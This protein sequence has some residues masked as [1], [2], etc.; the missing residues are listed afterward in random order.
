MRLFKIRYLLGLLLIM[1]STLT[2]TA[3][4][5]PADPVEP[6][7]V[8]DML[9]Y[10]VSVAASDADAATVSGSGKYKKGASV[11]VKATAKTGYKF[12]YW[13]K[14]GGTE[15]YNTASSFTYTMTA[16][17]V[18]FLA[19]FEKA[20]SVTVKI[21]DSNAGTVSGSTSSIYK[22]G[23]TTISTTAKTNYVFKYWLKDDETEPYSTDKSFKYTMQ[24]E[25]VTFT[26]VYEYVKPEY[27]PTDPA[28]PGEYLSKL[29]YR[30]NVGISDAEA[31]V[32]SGA[33][34][35]KYGT[36]V[37]VATS[38]NAGYE[39]R[40]WM[41]GEEEYSTA[42]SFNYTVS[43]EDVVFTAEYEYV[44][45]P[46]PV[47]TEHNVYLTASSTGCC[48]FN[49]VNGASVTIG[50]DFSVK[51]TPGTEFRF[52]GWYIGDE[53][54]CTNATYEGTMG[55]EDITLKAVC[56]YDPGYPVEPNSLMILDLSCATMTLRGRTLTLHAI[57]TSSAAM[58][59][60]S[61]SSS[62]TNVVT[63]AD[64]VVTAVDEGRATITAV[65]A[66]GKMTATCDITVM[67][68]GKG[69]VT[70]DGKITIADVSGAVLFAMGESALST[71]DLYEDAADYNNNG[72]VTVTDAISILRIVL[73]EEDESSGD[74]QEQASAPMRVQRK[75]SAATAVLSVDGA[76][77]N[78]GEEVS[79]PVNFTLKED[80][81]ISFQFD[82]VLPEGIKLQ[83]VNAGGNA[84]K[85]TITASRKKN[86]I[87]V[88]GYSLSNTPFATKVGEDILYLNLTADE[89]LA[90][91][92]YSITMN[93]I[94]LVR[95]NIST[96]TAA[97]QVM[98][99]KVNNDATAIDQ[100]TAPTLSPKSNIIYDM[101][102]RRVTNPTKGIY[103]VNGKKQR[104]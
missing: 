21:S 62:N 47:P 68:V 77:M 3:Q 97:K 1:G 19:V 36:S 10:K 75:A 81:F 39:F 84:S 38:A 18:S 5:N 63:V 89:S 50:D 64:G 16:E 27:K 13:T 60:S 66:D 2:A 30:V 17:D 29:S 33:G 48:T 28:E 4:Y 8:E 80:D 100:L 70:G 99:V 90:S 26:A 42:Q 40:R 94:E 35:Y 54:V 45:I 32:V 34:K 46:E 96:E 104:F 72:I 55:E 44:G 56:E 15:S 37:A 93:N 67:N 95:K 83:S 22:G 73:N 71:R 86:Y 92:E 51:A 58:E 61:W 87:R 98:T 23:S 20:K 85:Q 88:V 69:D 7:S 74:S 82:L 102:G 101:T 49:M 91:G 25:N 41:K 53:L 52:V 43:D 14:D 79:V 24:D 57:D 65:S 78:A 31:G 76:E 59:T 11:S 12:L 103:I 9:Y 6:G